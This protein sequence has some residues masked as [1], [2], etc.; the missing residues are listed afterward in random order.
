MFEENVS[1]QK[2]YNGDESV[3]TPNIDPLPPLPAPQI[4]VD[5]QLRFMININH[6]V[7]LVIYVRRNS[8]KSTES[9]Q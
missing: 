4:N 2:T 3:L 7:Q 1:Q 5:Y 8:L 9:L 6:L